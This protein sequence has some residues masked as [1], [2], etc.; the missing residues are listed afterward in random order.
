M[1]FFIIQSISS[2]PHV[3]LSKSFGNTD[4]SCLLFGTLQQWKEHG[5][6]M[7]ESLFPQTPPPVQA[8]S[9]GK[10]S[11]QDFGNLPVHTVSEERA[12]LLRVQDMDKLLPN[13]LQISHLK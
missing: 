8:K 4:F 5:T 1:P 10:T 6:D 13:S 11:F 2:L 9:V 7:S 12:A 3:P